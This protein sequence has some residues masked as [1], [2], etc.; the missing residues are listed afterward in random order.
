[1]RIRLFRIAVGVFLLGF[2]LS[3]VGI[4]LVATR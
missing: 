4:S 1:M 3:I 2:C